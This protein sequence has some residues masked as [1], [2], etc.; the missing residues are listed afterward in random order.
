M[1]GNA[2]TWTCASELTA[3]VVIRKVMPK[4]ISAKTSSMGREGFQGFHP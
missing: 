1:L 4:V 2:V 3:A